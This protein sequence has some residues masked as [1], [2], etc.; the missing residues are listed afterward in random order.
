VGHPDAIIPRFGTKRWDN[1]LSLIDASIEEDLDLDKQ[2]VE[3]QPIRAEAAM[4]P[5]LSPR[6]HADVGSRKRRIV[7]VMFWTYG[8]V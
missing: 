7:S 2:G 6:R 3:R 8:L 1:A 4:G 5:A